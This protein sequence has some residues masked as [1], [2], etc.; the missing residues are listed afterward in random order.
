V[1]LETYPYGTFV[2]LLGRRPPR[3]TTAAGRAARAELLRA[4]GL[5]VPVDAATAWRHDDLDAAAA[6]L[7]A[8]RHVRGDAVAVTCALDG[9]AVWLP[10]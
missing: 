6:A 1:P 4:T 5:D 2:T 9:T 10:A 8:L 3:K 7:V